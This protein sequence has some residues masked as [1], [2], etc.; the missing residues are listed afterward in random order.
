VRT[1]HSTVSRS[2]ILVLIETARGKNDLCE[3][4]R[5]FAGNAWRRFVL[6]LVGLA[7]GEID[8]RLKSGGSSV[9]H[10]TRT[11]EVP[12]DGE[13]GERHRNGSLSSARD[14]LAQKDVHLLPSSRGYVFDRIVPFTDLL[15]QERQNR[16][17][18]RAERNDCP[19]I[20][21]WD[22]VKLFESTHF[23]TWEKV[24]DSIFG[25]AAGTASH[26]ATADISSTETEINGSFTNALIKTTMYRLQIRQS[27]LRFVET[28]GAEKDQQQ[29]SGVCLLWD[30]TE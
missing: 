17:V 26:R 27:T 28:F 21:E 6:K 24:G 13:A 11:L 14:G 12:L 3:P 9:F 29:V 23:V 22:G 2:W 30:D 16:S 10:D 18:Y 20:L 8:S 7:V 25:H 4:P 5:I 19:Q 15:S 1:I